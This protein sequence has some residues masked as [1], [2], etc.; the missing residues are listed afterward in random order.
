MA[1]RVSNIVPID[2]QPRVAIG[3]SLPFNGTTGFNSTYIT[4]D[5]LKTNIIS[6]LLTNRGE[7]VFNFNCGADFGKF[8]FKQITEITIEDIKSIINSKLENRFPIKITK[9]DI[10]ADKDNNTI[11]ISFSYALKGTNIQ[12]TVSIDFN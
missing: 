2:L 4:S 7:R 1:Y 12:D 5:Q 8:I 10:I 3:I 6:Y 9:S 11:N